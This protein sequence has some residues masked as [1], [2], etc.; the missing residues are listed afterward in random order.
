MNSL[1][2]ATLLLGLLISFASAELKEFKLTPSSNATWLFQTFYNELSEIKY[3]VFVDTGYTG[4]AKNSPLVVNGTDGTNITNVTSD[5]D[6]FA[7]R[8]FLGSTTSNRNI[9]TY[10]NFRPEIM[11]TSSTVLVNDG[12]VHLIENEYGMVYKSMPN[13][14][15]VNSPIS[16]VKK[17]FAVVK[18]LEYYIMCKNSTLRLFSVTSFGEFE[19]KE[20]I[21][22]GMYLSTGKDFILSKSNSKLYVGNLLSTAIVELIHTLTIKDANTSETYAHDNVLMNVHN[23]IYSAV[24]DKNKIVVL[25][26]RDNFTQESY[27]TIPFYENGTTTFYDPKYI[28]NMASYGSLI[29]I[30]CFMCDNGK[31]R[32]YVYFDNYLTDSTGKY[33]KF[34]RFELVFMMNGT[35]NNK[36]FGLSLTINYKRIYIGGLGLYDTKKDQPSPNSTIFSIKDKLVNYCSGMY[37]NCIHGT[38]YDSNTGTC[39]KVSKKVIFVIVSILIVIVFLILIISIIL[40]IM[41]LRSLSKQKQEKPKIFDIKDTSGYW[42]P[43]DFPLVIKNEQLTFGEGLLDVGV[44]LHDSVTIANKEGSK[45]NYTVEIPESYRYEANIKFPSGELFKGKEAEIDIELTMKCTTTTTE[46]VKISVTDD[47]GNTYTAYIPIKIQTALSIYVD[48]EEIEE[49]KT[50]Q[51]I[52]EGSYGGVFKTV[53]KEGVVAVKMYKNSL[54]EEDL[55]QFHE[56][57]DIYKKIR[58][59]YIIQFIGFSDVPGHVMM[60][61]EYAEFGSVKKNYP[62]ESFNMAMAVKVIDDCANGMKVLHSLSIIHRDLKPDNLLLCSLSPKANV[63]AKI[64]DFGTSKNLLSMKDNATMTGTIGTPTYMAPEVLNNQEYDL[65]ADVYSFAMTCYEI[66]TKTVPFHEFSY[67]WNIGEKV[68]EGYRPQFPM[69]TSIPKTLIDLVEKCWSS[70]AHQRPIFDTIVSITRGVLTQQLSQIKEE[71]E[72]RKS[73]TKAVLQNEANEDG[74]LKDEQSNETTIDIVNDDVT[75]SILNAVNDSDPFDG[76]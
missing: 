20:T 9:F 18:D 14:V 37:C 45:Y 62:N 69:I 52:G 19:Q 40:M 39:E 26:P 8:I 24:T 34:N 55:E 63:C 21:P 47:K 31:G 2:R 60:V 46:S 33:K 42:V 59:E 76:F 54:T 32:V 10:K 38:Y 75:A 11:S 16:Y 12:S 15:D 71:K 35:E 27:L 70:D 17:S 53:Y 7:V 43:E 61:L 64:S 73:G 1:I 57:V 65:S 74:I 56:E 48:Y 30:G 5:M 25:D 49:C 13:F 68:N 66:L 41:Y 51:L 72:L 67:T 50:K 58:N 4:Y 29:A 23:V 44:P 36:Y 3:S 22:C 6:L 28:H